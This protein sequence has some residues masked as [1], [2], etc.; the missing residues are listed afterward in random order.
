MILLRLL[1]G[2]IGDPRI[3]FALAI[4]V[5]LVAGGCEIDRRATK[6]ERAVWLERVAEAERKVKEIEGRAHAEI[7]ATVQRAAEHNRRSIDAEQADKDSIRADLART[8]GDLDRCR[9]SRAV[10]MRLDAGSGRLPDSAGA[11]RRPQTRTDPAIPRPDPADGP[12]VD[13]GDLLVRA[14][15][16]SGVAERN[17]ERL[18]ACLAAYEATRQAAISAQ[19][20][21]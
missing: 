15:E 14:R 7:A 1:G 9:V 12:A 4:A 19:G 3:L 21:R 6:R 16:L 18:V 20:R 5:A 11:A 17:S 10:V 2:L 8:R 13:A